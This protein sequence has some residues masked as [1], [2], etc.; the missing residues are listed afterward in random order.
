MAD[1][2]EILLAP[3][4]EFVGA[5]RHVLGALGRLAEFDADSVED[6]KLAVS[7]AVTNAITREAAAESG[8]EVRVVATRDP[9]TVRIEVTDAGAAFDP[10][11]AEAAEDPGS[12]QA[13]S[14]EAG[15]S[16]PVVRGLVED[17]ELVPGEDG[18]GLTVR[19]TVSTGGG[20]G[21]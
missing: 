5:V 9:G 4:P 1:T 11:A 17:L 13:F 2:V 15:L 16:L 21:G 20:E 3:R 7:E 10:E 12:S 14:F 18:R 6:L 8:A 19:F